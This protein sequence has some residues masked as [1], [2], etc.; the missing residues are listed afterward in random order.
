MSQDH[1]A[2]RAPS[3]ATLWQHEGVVARRFEHSGA[4]ARFAIAVSRFNS[5]VTDSLLEGA[6][7]TLVAAGVPSEHITAVQV[8]GAVELPLACSELAK[9]RH[10]AGLIA[11]GCVIRGETSHYDYVCSAASDGLMRVQL[12]AGIPIGFGVLTCE[13]ADQAFAR[14]QRGDGRNAGS[15]AARA[16]LEMVALARD[17][18]GG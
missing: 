4:G 15:D 17:T 13:T 2:G 1:A 5:A 12:D 18:D 8:P 11:L 10:Y 14:A 16:T 6:V 7:R 3:G 9:T